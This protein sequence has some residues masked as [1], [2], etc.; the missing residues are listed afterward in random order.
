MSVYNYIE[1]NHI[2]HFLSTPT[3]HPGVHKYQSLTVT[4]FYAK[5][6]RISS[7]LFDWLEN[8]THSKID[9]RFCSVAEPNRTPIV[10]LSS[11]G[12]LFD[13]VRLD[14]QGIS[15]SRNVFI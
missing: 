9:V 3:V 2:S 12:F 8:Q 7:I 14:T 15:A 6:H 4:L 5:L 11:I 10:R 1:D 13:F